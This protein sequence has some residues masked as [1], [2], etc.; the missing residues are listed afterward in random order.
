MPRLAKT[1]T[2]QIKKLHLP[3]PPDGHG[4]LSRLVLSRLGRA[5]GV[6]LAGRVAALVA[7]PGL[8]AGELQQ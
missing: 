2:D 3:P 5:L 8:F 1:L 4:P 7:R 6:G